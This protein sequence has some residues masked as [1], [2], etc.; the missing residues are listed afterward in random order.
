MK[1]EIAAICMAHDGLLLSRI[2]GDFNQI[3]GLRVEN[4]LD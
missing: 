3:P 4:W 1:R 2:L